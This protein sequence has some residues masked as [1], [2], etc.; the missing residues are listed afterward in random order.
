[1]EHEQVVI[2]EQEEERSPRRSR[3]KS[4]QQ[5]QRGRSASPARRS[6]SK[7]PRKS[8]PRHS[9]SPVRRSE[10]PV[11][12]RATSP[13]DSQQSP[14]HSRR[15]KSP[16]PAS[17][18]HSRRSPSKSPV[19]QRRS[20]SPTP[21]AATRQRSKSPAPLESTISPEVVIG[22]GDLQQPVASCAECLDFKKHLNNDH[23]I[24]QE[25]RSKDLIK[26]WFFGNFKV[27][28]DGRDDAFVIGRIDFLNQYIN[29]FLESVGLPKWTSKSKLYKDYFLRELNNL[30]TDDLR[31]ARP[32]RLCKIITKEQYVKQ[33]EELLLKV[34][35]V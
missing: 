15:S 27:S 13:I 23:N 18:V 30:S 3:S 7:S 35:G 22:E 14:V 17:P 28:D 2:Q 33:L 11:R 34:K 4:P 26:A 8:P 20:R 5:Q 10:S 32:W 24:N 6:K 1:M 16:C 9:V 19:R 29:P 31:K 12:S 25:D 21:P